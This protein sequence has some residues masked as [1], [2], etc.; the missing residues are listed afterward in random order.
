MFYIKTFGGIGNADKTAPRDIWPLNM[1]LEDSKLMI[2]NVK[3][4]IELLKE[5]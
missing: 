4:A 1:D 5:F 2:T 3:M